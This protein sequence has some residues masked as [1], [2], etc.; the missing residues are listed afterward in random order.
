MAQRQGRRREDGDRRTG[1]AL[2]G[3]DVEDDIGGMDTVADS[4]GTGRLDRRQPVG[5]HRGENVDHL[6]IAVVIA[7]ELAPGRM[8]YFPVVQQCEQGEHRWVEIPAAGKHSNEPAPGLMLMPKK[9]E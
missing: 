7:G 5:E 6:S 2:A 9:Q 4:L 3:Q 1:I 8:L